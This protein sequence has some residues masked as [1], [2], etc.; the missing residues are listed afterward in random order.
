MK[1]SSIQHNSDAR[2]H[3]KSTQNGQGLHSGPPMDSQ[4]IT[5]PIVRNSDLTCRS[6]WLCEH[7]YD[8]DSIDSD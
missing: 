5:S 3:L 1:Y 8:Q 6:P 2:N 7:R 4:G